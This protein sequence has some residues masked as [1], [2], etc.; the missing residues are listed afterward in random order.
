MFVLLMAYGCNNEEM[1]TPTAPVDDTFEPAQATLLST[2]VMM[3]NAHT[4]SGTATAY[5]NGGS[6][7]IVLDPFSTQNGP[8]LKVYLSTDPN[9]TDYINLGP[10]KS[11]MG[12]QSYPVAGM[13]DLTAYRFV[14]IWCEQ[15]S[16]LFGKAELQ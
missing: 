13:P 14:L 6:K 4:V 8:D 2:G 1:N 10:L 12:K 5:D 3:G 9:A 7:T 16:V 11:T 15:F